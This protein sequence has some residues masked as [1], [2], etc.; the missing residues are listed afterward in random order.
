MTNRAFAP[1]KINLTLHV[2]GQR[3]DG[4][5][6]LD[7]L[8]VFADIGDDLVFTPADALS[9]DV[10]G[11]FAAGVPTDERNLVWRAALAADW[12][13][14]IDLTKNLP[15]GGGI[16]G[17]SAD[18]AAVLRQLQAPQAALD[19]GADVPVCLSNQPQ[20]MQGI[21]EQL[22]YASMVPELAIVLINPGV[23]VP[24]P[25]IFAALTEKQNPPMSDFG[26]WD[27]RAGFIQWLKMQRNDLQQT[28]LLQQPAIAQV[29]DALGD[30]LLTRMSGSGA[31]CF[32]IY[33]EKTA[34]QA[35]A[36]R[37]SADQPDWWVRAVSTF[38]SPS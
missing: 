36:Q 18:A 19:L 34:A 1:A 20:R 5:H 28:A 37:I 22:T 14:H 30:A 10:C 17:G 4:Y 21:G 3:A 7:S 26:N 15:H 25:S 29:L 2:T 27:G 12:Q 24:T 16:G 33:P 9:L 31:S 35:A 13:G 6:L 23:N 38:V 11:P 32:G 8:V